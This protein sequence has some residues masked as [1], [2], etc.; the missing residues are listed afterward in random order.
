MSID[1][2]GQFTFPGELAARVDRLV[3]GRKQRRVVR[4]ETSDVSGEVADLYRRMA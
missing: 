2:G 3:L 4:L 1:P